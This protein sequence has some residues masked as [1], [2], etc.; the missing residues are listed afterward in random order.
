MTVSIFVRESAK[1]R[2]SCNV[3]QQVLSEVV[4][5]AV[6]D[7]P[8]GLSDHVTIYMGPGA[9]SASKPKHK[10]IKSRDK[11]PSK[12]NSL[13]HFLMEVPLSSLL[14]SDQ[15]CAGKL[16]LL[17]EVINYG[18]DTIMPVRSI[19]IHETDRP[20]VSLQL[21]Q[22]IIRR[23]KAFTSGNLP[24]FKI[25]R[26]KVNRVPK[27]CRKVYY[28]NKVKDLHDSKP[29]NWW[30]EVKQLCGSAKSSSG[31]DLT[32]ILHLDLVCDVPWRG[33]NACLP[34]DINFSWISLNF[35]AAFKPCKWARNRDRTAVKAR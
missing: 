3:S 11:C 21:K 17:T 29:H 7:L 32:S 9:C 12:V 28:E 23:Q 24:L 15:S 18:L 8:F 27:R 33:K 14:S 19:T 34:R 25:L 5:A 20:W 4:V 30:R 31:R 26:N 10:T 22:L 6:E 35:Q 13:G 2:Y 16:S 1:N